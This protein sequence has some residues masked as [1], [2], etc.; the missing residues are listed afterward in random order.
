LAR[1][2]VDR[3]TEV[4]KTAKELISSGRD[5]GV[6]YRIVRPDG[7]IRLLRSAAY[8]QHE[9]GL[10][11]RAVGFVLDI[12]DVRRSELALRDENR[13]LEDEKASFRRQSLEDPLTSI[14]N[15]RYLDDE[16]ERICHDR[17]YHAMRI[18]IA[19]IDIDHFKLYN[20]MYGHHRG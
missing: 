6:E 11:K 19:L 3:A 14:P 4:E 16:L 15:R 5:Y 10:A 1:W 9:N 17:G 18:C 2:F 13:T 12:T 8:L 7:E 20:D